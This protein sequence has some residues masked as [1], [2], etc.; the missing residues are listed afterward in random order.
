MMPRP[1]SIAGISAAGRK[2]PCVIS[3]NDRAQVRWF[4]LVP[5]V[6]RVVG[7]GKARADFETTGWRQS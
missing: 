4:E 3:M 5:I 1:S 7:A 2:S 6:E